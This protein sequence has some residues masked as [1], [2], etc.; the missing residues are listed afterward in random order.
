MVIVVPVMFR[1]ACSL[2]CY[3]VLYPVIMFYLLVFPFIC[4]CLLVVHVDVGDGLRCMTAVCP[5]YRCYA[6][7]I[8]SSWLNACMSWHYDAGYF[9][10]KSNLIITQ[11]EYV[12]DRVMVPLNR[13]FPSA[14]TFAGMGRPLFVSLS[15][16]RSVPPTRAGYGR[17]VRW[18]GKQA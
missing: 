13:V 9:H 17:A 8:A 18:P 3:V 11:L 6:C 2:L 16:L 4:L 1:F 12:V 5:E 7:S 10:F 14:T 15:C